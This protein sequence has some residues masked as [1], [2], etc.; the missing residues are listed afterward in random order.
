MFKNLFGRK[1]RTTG[2][3][4]E[5][6]PGEDHYR[7]YVGPP[8]DYDR[9]AAMTF[10]LL[11]CLGLRED[12]VALDVGCGSLRIG[13]L[14][15]PYLA[16]GNYIGVEPNEWLVNDGIINEL[17]G[18]DLVRLKRPHF[19]FRDSIAGEPNLPKARFAFAQSIFSHCGG[20]LVARWLNELHGALTED[21][22]LVA[23]HWPGNKDNDREGWIYPDCVGFTVETM[24]ALGEA[25][26]FR[27]RRLDWHHPT[28]FWML[29]A[30]PGFE[31]AALETGEVSWN[32]THAESWTRRKRK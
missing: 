31:H 6:G 29:Y 27:V 4:L 28:Q 12:D 30:K 10:N 22:A 16:P 25:A 26:G 20:D 3:G 21:G 15:I 17:G 5:H 8:A 9:I 32:G 11:T 13:R 2:R 1:P 19:V 23:T 24:Q 7:A 14:L 18:E